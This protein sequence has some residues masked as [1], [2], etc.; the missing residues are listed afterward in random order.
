MHTPLSTFTRLAAILSATAALA[1]GAR[2]DEPPTPAVQ[3]AMLT[4]AQAVTLAEAT[5][6]GI[7]YDMK[8]TSEGS[9]VVYRI[10]VSTPDRGIVKVHVAAYGGRLEVQPNERGSRRA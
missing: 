9:A 5:Q 10:K 7:A 4:M 8:R 2:A 3:P 6:K 1:A